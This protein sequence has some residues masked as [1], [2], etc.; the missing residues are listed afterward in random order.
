MCK[1]VSPR[2]AN[3]NIWLRR[4]SAHSENLTVT[5]CSFELT[6]AA[7]AP[8][9]ITHNIADV[10]RGPVLQQEQ[11]DVQV[12][13]EGCYVD[14]RQTRLNTGESTTETIGQN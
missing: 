6:N 2:C 5:L 7:F 14:G 12:T 11:D 10:S 3:D 4:V 9:H 1:A 8:F 13:H